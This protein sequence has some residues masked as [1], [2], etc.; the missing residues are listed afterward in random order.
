MTYAVDSDRFQNDTFLVH[1]NDAGIG[2]DLRALGIPKDKAGANQT[3]V[4]CE[5]GTLIINAGGNQLECYVNNK[6][7]SPKDLGAN[8]EVGK[9]AHW[10]SWIEQAL[11]D[12]EVKV[13]TPFEDAL[14]MTEC[15]ILPVKA[16]RFPGQQLQWDKQTLTFPNN[17]E[18]TD[19][20]VRR[21]YRDGFRP[22][23]V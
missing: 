6:L 14:R 23:K 20:V 2:Y 13:W 18:A 22:V 1:Y 4:V 11:G 15:A 19:T 7:V 10:G 21:D 12:Q 16:S 8:T 3:I 9:Y 5:N 17:Q